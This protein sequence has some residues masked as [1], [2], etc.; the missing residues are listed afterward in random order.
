MMSKLG[1]VCNSK[2]CR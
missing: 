2:I 1:K